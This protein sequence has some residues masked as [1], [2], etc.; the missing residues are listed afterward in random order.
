MSDIAKLLARTV[1]PRVQTELQ[2]HLRGFFRG[3]VRGYLPQTWWFSTESGQATLS[4]S[5][6]GVTQ[7]RDGQS[8]DPDVSIAWTDKAF[9][10]ALDT[11]DRT[12]LP[13]STPAPKVEVHTPKG[14]AA[15]GQ[16]RKRL[17]L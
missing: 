12:Q 6:D 2:H 14:K 10:I 5:K 7:V 13:A 8:G 15:Y 16:L 3:I 1:A 17:G 4:V 11:G 9:R